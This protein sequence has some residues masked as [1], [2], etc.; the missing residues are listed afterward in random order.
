[1]QTSAGQLTWHLAG[2]DLDLFRHVPTLAAGDPGAPTWDGHTTAEK[3]ARMRTLA[4]R[5][6]ADPERCPSC[7]HPW[8][9]FHQ[10]DGCWFAIGV[11]TPGHDLVCP[12]TVSRR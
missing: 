4:R 3:Y 2:A 6:R 8:A 9:K 5:L 12:C 11:G 10:P 7:D 1:M